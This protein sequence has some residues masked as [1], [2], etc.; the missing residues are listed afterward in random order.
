[1]VCGD[2][3]AIGLGINRATAEEKRTRGEENEERE[4]C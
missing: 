1:M 3:P 4:R 2:E